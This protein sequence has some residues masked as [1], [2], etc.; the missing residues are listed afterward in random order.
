MSVSELNRI[1][2]KY[3]ITNADRTKIRN[4]INPF[5]TEGGGLSVETIDCDQVQKFIGWCAIEDIPFFV[6]FY[7]KKPDSAYVLAIADDVDKNVDGTGGCIEECVVKVFPAGGRPRGHPDSTDAGETPFRH[8][9]QK[10]GC[11]HLVMREYFTDSGELGKWKTAREYDSAASPFK[12]FP[13]VCGLRDELR[14]F[15]VYG[16]NIRR[17]CTDDG[18]RRPGLYRRSR[19]LAVDEESSDEGPASSDEEEESSSSDE[20]PAPSEEEEESSVEFDYD[21]VMGEDEG[22][23]AEEPPEEEGSVLSEEDTSLSLPT[24]S[25]AEEVRRRNEIRRARIERQKSLR[26]ARK[27]GPSFFK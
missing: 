19:R 5:S 27:R 21:L 6:R 3:N 25:I 24:T 10:D 26:S 16:Q 12:A 18:I 9:F 2:Q 11:W 13:R 14:S 20:G 1:R 7:A 15:S 22:P 17:D 4:Q 8:I 23:P